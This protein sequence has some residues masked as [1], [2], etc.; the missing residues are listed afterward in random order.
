M[1]SK[2]RETEIALNVRAFGPSAL[3]KAQTDNN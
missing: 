2:I 3:L 1:S